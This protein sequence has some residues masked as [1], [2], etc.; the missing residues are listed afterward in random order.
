M[1]ETGRRVWV[2]R[3]R[4]DADRTA[5]RLTALGY[6][7]VMQPLLQ[8]VDLDLPP[9]DLD[10]IAALAFTSRNGVRAF[11]G[12]TPRR[13]RP[14]FTVG[15][16]TAQACREEGFAEVISADGDATGLGRLIAQTGPDGPVLWPTARAPGADLTGLAA[17]AR[18]V[19]L[20]VYETVEAPIGP[21]PAFDAVLLHSAR[22]AGALSARLSP[23]AARGRLAV[24]LSPAV[25]AALSGLPFAEVRIAAAP[26][27]AA[28]LEALGKVRPGL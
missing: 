3:A 16:A 14:V 4:P 5:D 8:V 2:T 24:A 28:L 18:V 17:P 25:A 27:E 10:G 6:E 19:A 12:L 26:D 9:P 23:D 13:D 7:P 1:S 20:A 15:D 11:A 21:P 22:A